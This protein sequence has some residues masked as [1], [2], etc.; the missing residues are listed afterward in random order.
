P[1]THPYMH[2]W[3]CT[4]LPARINYSPNLHQHQYK[5]ALNTARSSHYSSII[6]SGSNN[7][8][9]LFSTINKPMDTIS[10]SFITNKCNSFLSFFNDKIIAIHNQLAASSFPTTSPPSPQHDPP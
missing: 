6:Q 7:P 4:S 1:Y 10:T 9:T 8:R 5:D 3:A 2:K